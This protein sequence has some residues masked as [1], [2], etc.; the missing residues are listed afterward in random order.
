MRWTNPL[1]GLMLSLVAVALI[2]A[3]CSKEENKGAQAMNKDALTEKKDAGTGKKTA[4]DGDKKGHEGYWC[5]E[6]GVPEEMCSICMSAAEAKNRFKDKGDWCQLHDRAQSQC[7]K[8]DPKLYAKYEAMYEAKFGKKP[9]RPP[10][11]EFEN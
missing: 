1:A 3:G 2:V 10:E 11:S 9:E 4:Q 6:H 8:C 7:F 5:E